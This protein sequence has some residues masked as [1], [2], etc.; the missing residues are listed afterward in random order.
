M[1]TD[2]M[3][4]Y[5]TRST[6]AAAPPRKHQSIPAAIV[7]FNRQGTRHEAG[8]TVFKCIPCRIHQSGLLHPAA[9]MSTCPALNRSKSDPSPQHVGP[10]HL[11]NTWL[12]CTRSALAQSGAPSVTRH[13]PSNCKRVGEI[14]RRWDEILDADSAK[15]LPI[16]LPKA[17]DAARHNRVIQ[18]DARVA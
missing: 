10:M 4:E 16:S 14:P 7:S 5:R 13:S 6:T 3:N 11:R 17:T 12:P 9:R 18:A 15:A 8:D 2:L 1:N